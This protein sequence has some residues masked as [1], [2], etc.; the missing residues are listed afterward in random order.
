[1]NMSSNL[2]RNN[3]EIYLY[4]ASFMENNNDIE[5]QYKFVFEQERYW[6]RVKC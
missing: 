3:V 1:M 2:N 5:N 6:L 4:G